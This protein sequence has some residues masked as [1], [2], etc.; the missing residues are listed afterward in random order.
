M[1]LP[2][3]AAV[4]I[5][6][7]DAISSRDRLVSVPKPPRNRHRG[8]RLGKF[9]TRSIELHFHVGGWGRRSG[10]ALFVRTCRCVRVYPRENALHNASDEQDEGSPTVSIVL[11]PLGSSF[12]PSRSNHAALGEDFFI[13]F[14]RIPLTLC[15]GDFATCS[16]EAV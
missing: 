13:G 14:R 5:V 16:L 9:S 10:A 4:V 8:Q 2:A 11:V 3:A 7:Y 1:V 12:N 6:I 15:A